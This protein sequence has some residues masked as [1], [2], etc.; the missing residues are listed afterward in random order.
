MVVPY[1]SLIEL[2]SDDKQKKQTRTQWMYQSLIELIS[3]V[4][5]IVNAVNT[6]PCINLL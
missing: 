5:A 3:D 1:Q 2:I 6:F 4:P